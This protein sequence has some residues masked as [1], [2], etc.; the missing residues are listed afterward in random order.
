MKKKLRLAPALFLASCAP[1]ITGG[2]AQTQVMATPTTA[3]VV[4]PG[5]TENV[6]F[7]YSRNA[8]KVNDKYFA[9]LKVD[10]A[11]RVGSGVSSPRAYAPWLKMTVKDQLPKG[12]NIALNSA[13]IVK[14]IRSTDNNQF[15]TTVHFYEIVRVTLKVTA[16]PDATIGRNM[17][18]VE[19]SDGNTPSTV[20]VVIDVQAKK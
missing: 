15:D 5:E 1:S 16:A 3:I 6:Q 17:V 8:I 7:D 13:Y 14:D 12:V 11:D 4:H 18:D 19:Y 20:P 10:F 2:A 9:D